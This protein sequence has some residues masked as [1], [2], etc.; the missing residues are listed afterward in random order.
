MLE[1]LT[2]MAKRSEIG[3]TIEY[4]GNTFVI[5]MPD[6]TE[7]LETG[8]R[9][10]MVIDVTA[11]YPTALLLVPEIIEEKTLKRK[12][13]AAAKHQKEMEAFHKKADA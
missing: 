1:F 3:R 12:R 10:H 9:V 11:V 6:I 5:V 2:E 8:R 13:A 4:E 7:N